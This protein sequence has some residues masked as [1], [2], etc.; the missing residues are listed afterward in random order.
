M[1]TVQQLK[2]ARRQ[3]LLGLFQIDGFQFML[4]ES[5]SGN[6]SITCSCGGF[7]KMAQRLQY[8]I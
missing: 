4:N 1:L 5:A 8:L 7:G 6:R 3:R 2:Q